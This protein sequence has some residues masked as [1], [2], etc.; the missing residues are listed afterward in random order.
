M[1]DIAWI[2]IQSDKCK[3][4]STSTTRCNNTPLEHQTNKNIHAC[5]GSLHACKRAIE[6][7]IAAKVASLTRSLTSYYYTHLQ[8]VSLHVGFSRLS[9]W[10]NKYFDSAKLMEDG[11][12]MDGVL[13]DR[14]AVQVKQLDHELSSPCMYIHT[15]MHEPCSLGEMILAKAILPVNPCLGC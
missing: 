12:R 8:S 9:Q 6:R 4:C 3:W 13:H 15:H 5:I 11:C 1:A 14:L 10:L 2:H 7:D